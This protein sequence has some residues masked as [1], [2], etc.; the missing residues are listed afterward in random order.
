MNIETDFLNHIHVT[1]SMLRVII[2]TFLQLLE[3]E[4]KT[5][6]NTGNYS[7]FNYYFPFFV[8]QNGLVDLI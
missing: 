6:I 8:S 3:F 1:S 5:C 4:K 7:G 2:F